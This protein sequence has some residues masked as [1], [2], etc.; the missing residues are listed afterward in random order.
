MAKLLSLE[1]YHVDGLDRETST[2]QWMNQV[3]DTIIMR[4]NNHSRFY[5]GVG[6]IYDH[7]KKEKLQSDLL[8]L[9][10]LNSNLETCSNNLQISQLL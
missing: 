5:G 10:Q 1:H 3:G 8:K 6:G 4:Y 2:K 7:F 9:L